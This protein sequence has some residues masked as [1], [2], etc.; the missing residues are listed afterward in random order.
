[1]VLEP[2]AQSVTTNEDGSF[3]FPHLDPLTAAVSVNAPGFQGQRT[4]LRVSNQ[5]VMEL[6]LILFPAIIEETVT[7]MA[8]TRT[9][10]SLDEVPVRTEVVLPELMELSA[11]RNLADALEFSPGIRV[12]SNCQN[13]NFSQIR[14]LGLQGPYTQILFDGQPT[15]SSLAQVYGIEQIPSRMVERIEV[16][17]GGGSSIYGPGSVGG[18]VNI[19]SHVPSRT[20]GYLL[21]RTG[22]MNGVPNQTFSA[23]ADWASSNRD[24]AVTIFGQGDKVNPVDVDRDGF[25]EVSKRDFRAMGGRFRQNFLDQKGELTVD[26]NRFRE[27]RRGGDRLDLPPERSSLAEA[28]ESTRSAGGVG[29]HH[30]PSAA[31]DYRLALSVA[32]MDRDTYYGSGQDPNAFGTSR[33]PL[34]VVDSQFNHFL[35]SHI[36]SWGGQITSDGIEDVQPAYERSYDETYRNFGGFIQ[37]DWFLLP[38]LELVWGGRLDKHSAITGPVFSP[39][40]ALMWTANPD[41]HVRTSVAT[42]F[43]APRV[44]DEDLHITVAGGKAQVIRNAADLKEESS[45]TLMAGAEWKPRWGDGG[46]L[47]EVNLFRTTLKNLF[48]VVEDDLPETEEMEFT[49]VNFGTAKVY[50]AEINLGYVLNP[51]IEI[52]VGYVEQRSRFENPEP[53]FGSRDFFRT[54]NRYGLT[55]LVCRNPRLVDVFLGMRYNGEMSLPHYA[56]WIAEDRLETSP[57]N[58]SMDAS[59]SRSF[60]IGSDAGLTLTLGGKNLTNTYQDDLDRGPQRDSGYVWGPRFPRTLYVSTTVEF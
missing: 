2:S 46:G 39:R 4:D 47:V 43:L 19:V 3:C 16:V 21:A 22:W 50:G 20:T 59:L 52:Q 51:S 34:W 32:R 35:G 10:K 18:V 33:N 11:S 31:F 37:D 13:C 14:M 44:F 5:P 40:L 45:T 54:P 24:S 57:P 7:V 36:L 15:M 28:V 17:K 30:T 8:A 25:T 12:E 27:K 9:V 60:S 53:D 42:G 29:W 41:L 48:N 26:F 23:S 49:R 55:T 56:G 1:V 58:W 38:G 6:N